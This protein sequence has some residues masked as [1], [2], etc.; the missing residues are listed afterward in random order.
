MKT[1]T[2]FLI[3]LVIGWASSAWGF[4]LSPTELEIEIPAGSEK[5]CEL[6]IRNPTEN[7]I[8]CTIRASELAIEKDG[9]AL[10][11]GTSPE[12]SAVLWTMIEEPE[13]DLLPRDQKK[14]KIKISAPSNAKSHDYFAAIMATKTSAFVGRGAG[15]EISGSMEI[16]G[17]CFLRI[18]VPGRKIEKMPEVMEARAEVPKI[19]SETEIKVVSIVR[20][21]SQIR[22]DVIGKAT[23]K[24]GAN[25]IVDE[26][27]LQ[28]ANKAKGMA[29]VQPEGMRK[30]WGIVQKP[31]LPGDYMVDISFAYS[32]NK[33]EEFKQQ[34]ND[35][36]P[37]YRNS[38]KVRADNSAKF[39]VSPELGKSQKEL[40]AIS[41]P[42][43]LEISM[44]TGATFRTLYI[45]IL[46]HEHESIKVSTETNADWLKVAPEFFT[47]WGKTKTARIDIVIPKGGPIQRSCLVS[48]TPERGKKINIQANVYEYRKEQKK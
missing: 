26:F 12:Y 15:R 36:N 6:E 37:L 3:F 48:F 27:F 24:D 42:D 23:I 33:F 38:R 45:E 10:F 32:F 30:F 41:A 21:N 5:V 40:L 29:F 47:I 43:L 31:L 7:P 25:R 17:V 16:R 8:S 34:S 39:T 1:T 22:M 13:V 44:P 19:E 28:G 11:Q 20:N 35:T 9:K 46:N 4:F 2:L 18:S 14:V